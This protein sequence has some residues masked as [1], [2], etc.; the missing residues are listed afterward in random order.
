VFNAAGRWL[1]GNLH[2]HTK[3]SDGQLALEDALAF[4]YR[5]GYD[6]LA[7]SDHRQTTEIAE[8][9]C[10]GLLT[11][12]AIEL[13]CHDPERQVGYHV[14]GLGVTPF[15]QDDSLRRGPGQQLVDAVRSAGGIA[16]L[17]HPYWLGQDIADLLAV[18]GAFAVEVFNATCARHGKE[19]GEMHW[20]GLLQRGLSIWG[21][22]T[23]D[24][25]IYEHDAAQGW[26]MVRAAELTRTAVLNAL[27]AGMFYST[28]GPAILDIGVDDGSIWVHCSSVQEVRFVGARGTGRSV[29]AAVGETLTFARVNLLRSPYVRVECIDGLGK[30]AWSQPIFLQ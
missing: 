1:R 4:Y 21:V 7:V 23:D 17:A 18:E 30:A 20:D 25:H 3:N 5:Q 27:E 13:D 29:R 6:F 8:S 14:V 2:T 16:M 12:P 22:A 9:A 24:T 15:A 10:P 26:V 19:R 28:C 11:I